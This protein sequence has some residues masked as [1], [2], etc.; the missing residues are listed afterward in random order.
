MDLG[1]AVKLLDAAKSAGAAHYVMVSSI[2]ADPSASEGD[3]APYLR[4]KGRADE[5]VRAGGIPHTIVR[6][7]RL[8]NDPGSGRVHAAPDAE[9]GDI[10]RDDVAAVLAAVLAGG[11]LDTTFVLVSG[12][13]AID[14]ALTALRAG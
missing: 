1:G 8:T 9:R 10:P 6:P 14:E 12:D 11:P 7:G 4:A 13:D 3:M 2:G 5:A